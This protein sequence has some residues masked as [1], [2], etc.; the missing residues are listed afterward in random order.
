MAA[1]AAGH[2]P[3]CR[4][5]G[6]PRVILAKIWGLQAQELPTHTEATKEGGRAFSWCEICLSILLVP[7]SPASIVY[8]I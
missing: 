3:P 4:S 7:R 6:L 8:A 1:S 5:L 2:S